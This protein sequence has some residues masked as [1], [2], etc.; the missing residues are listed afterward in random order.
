[1]HPYRHGA[2]SFV[3]IAPRHRISFE[4]GRGLPGCFSFAPP[5]KNIPIARFPRLRMNTL[6]WKDLWR[7]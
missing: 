6:T 7:R 5:R 2:Q 1:M 4:G 3:T